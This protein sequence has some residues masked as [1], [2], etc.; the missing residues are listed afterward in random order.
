MDVELD[1]EL[2]VERNILVVFSYV[3]WTGK[4]CG[5]SLGNIAQYF[6]AGADPWYLR[7][8]L[9]IRTRRMLNTAANGNHPSS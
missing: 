2:D 5:T 4:Y 7:W 6:P 1:V 3:E 8:S 9:P